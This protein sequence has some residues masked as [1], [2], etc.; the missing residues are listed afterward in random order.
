[1]IQ[2]KFTQIN[3][4]LGFILNKKLRNYSRILAQGR[5]SGGSW[6]FPTKKTYWNMFGHLSELQTEHNLSQKEVLDV[7]GR[8]ERVGRRITKYNYF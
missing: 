3:K 1:M 7:Y 6:I 4:T 5:C 2:S 8:S